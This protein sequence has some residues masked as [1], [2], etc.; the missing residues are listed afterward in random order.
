[1]FSPLGAVVGGEDD[2]WGRVD[3]DAA[4][5][6]KKSKGIDQQE[7]LSNSDTRL[8]AHLGLRIEK[9]NDRAHTSPPC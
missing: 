5:S 7:L 4:S 2:G 8:D 6:A 1:M 9:N 3:A